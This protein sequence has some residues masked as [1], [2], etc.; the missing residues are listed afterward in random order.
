MEKKF[1][2]AKHIVLNAASYIKE[3][4][5]DQ[6]QI[7]TKS[8]PTDLVTQM[9]KEVQDNLVT[10]ILEA[11]PADHILAEENDLRHSISDGNVW[12]IDPIDGTNNFVAQKADFA[13]VLAY[14]ENGIGQFDV[15]C[16]EQKLLPYQDRPLNQFLIASNAGIF[17]RNDW[18]I[19]DLAK[20]T[21]GVRV[22]GSAAISFSKVLS[23]QL[24][25]YISYICPW[26]YAAAS[27][28]G[29]KLGYTTVTFD[30]KQPDFESHQGIMMIPMMK[31]DEIKKYIYRKRED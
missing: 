1:N 12:V 15:Y 28:M 3:H 18:G 20:E 30:G 11:Y 23:G 9:D 5:N 13:V 21:L 10:W 4:L 16:N 6:L 29:D 7:E 24:L 27:I 19:A 8:S 22:Y 17:E 31:L 26:D 14:F 2:F 25:T